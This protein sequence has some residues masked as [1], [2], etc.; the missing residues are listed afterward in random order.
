LFLARDAL[1][2]KSMLCKFFTPYIC[3]AD[4]RLHL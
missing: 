2:W 1:L 3:P 4:L